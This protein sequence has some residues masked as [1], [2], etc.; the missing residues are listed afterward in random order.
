MQTATR[1]SI[2]KLIGYQV[3]R[4]AVPRTWAPGE[5]AKEMDAYYRNRM[6]IMEYSPEEAES[7]TREEY[8]SVPGAG[9]WVRPTQ[10]NPS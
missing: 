6:E 8:R 5:A 1:G 4:M 2:E 9:E 7:A 10:E 3:P